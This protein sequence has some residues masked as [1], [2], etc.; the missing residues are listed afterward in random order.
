MDRKDFLRTALALTSMGTLSSFKNFTDTLPTQ[1]EKMPVLF[2]SHGSPM[3]I[4]LSKDDRAFWNSLFE[5]GKGLQNKFEVKAALVVSAHWN[6]RGT[7]VNIS[8]E[9]EQ[10]F[11][12]YG[13]PKEYTR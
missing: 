7:F 3:D 11:D 2:T 12:Y 4:P 8:P 13:F 6:T 1:S 9:Q 10:I 5:L